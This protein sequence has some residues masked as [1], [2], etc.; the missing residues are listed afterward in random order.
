VRRYVDIEASV[1][2][3]EEEDE[4]GEVGEDFCEG[5]FPFRQPC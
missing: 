1:D 4:G 5:I 3:E 2:D